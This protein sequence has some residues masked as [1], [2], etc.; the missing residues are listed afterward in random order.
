[1]RIIIVDE[2]PSSLSN[3]TTFL[4][5]N[6]SSTVIG[7][8]NTR[9]AAAAAE[10]GI[11]DILVSQVF[12]ADPDEDGFT[13][14]DQ[15][16]EVNPEL[17]TAFASAYPLD[18]FADYI[19]ESAV[20][21]YPPFD[22]DG[23]LQ[24]IET[25]KKPE[26]RGTIDQGT[27]P[28]VRYKLAKKGAAKEMLKKATAAS[29]ITISSSAESPPQTTAPAAT[30]APTE[31]FKE[32]TASTGA[33][34][35]PPQTQIGDYQIVRRLRSGAE[36]L[37][38]EALQ[39]SVNRPVALELL[40]PEFAGAEDTVSNF[41]AQVRAKAAIVNP[42]IA[43]VYEAL[44]E[45][46]TVFY[47]RELLDGQSL[48]ELATSGAKLP[49]ESVMGIIST[50]SEAYRYLL[51]N[52]I[53]TS[54]LKPSDIIL[55]Q[56]GQTRVNNLALAEAD[57][58][59]SEAVDVRT[60]GSVLNHLTDHTSPS[61]QEVNQLILGTG[62]SNPIDQTIGTWSILS[63]SIESI[64]QKIAEEQSMRPPEEPVAAT[65][66]GNIPWI[67]IAGGIAAVTIGA[68]AASFLLGDA[69][70]DIGK[71]EKSV[72][73]AAGSFKYQETDA[74]V[75]AFDIDAYEV[76]IGQYVAFL[77][78]LKAN[79]S[80]SYSDSRQPASKG[81]HTP[82]AWDEYYPIAQEGGVFKG[83][84]LSLDCPVFNVDWWDATAY[85]KWKGRRLPTEQE[86]E[87]AGRGRVANSSLG[88]T[89]SPPKKPTLAKTMPQKTVAKPMATTSGHP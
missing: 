22:G 60:L 6:T 68:I 12:F 8:N 34:P 25:D 28:Q 5:E 52:K 21:Y 70:F 83:Q 15:L 45:G 88:A 61:H 67:P 4:Q 77:D 42:H 19:K 16:T 32:E 51:G 1:M 31:N 27:T 57:G 75:S 58:K 50:V 87:R 74:T 53:P 14:R 38:Y 40:N 86:W 13:I 18:E 11:P 84:K 81:D 49:R 46:G 89:P 78:H 55:S 7:V 80:S 44:E 35:L 33:E 10:E 26:V 85:A 59:Q 62:A 36:V 56:D 47:T 41:R 23:L 54:S 2:N 43:P 3:L 39:I 69:D 24:W 66:G 17:R 79:S 71:F 48:A 64:E 65:G 63:G 9:G 76:T 72:P 73:V 20:F 82:K 29:P 30:A 37:T